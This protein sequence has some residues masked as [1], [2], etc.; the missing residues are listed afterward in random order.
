MFHATIVAV[1]DGDFRTPFS[2]EAPP[3]ARIVEFQ[4]FIRSGLRVNGFI[5]RSL[6]SGLEI[7]P[8]PQTPT[9]SELKQRKMADLHD[10]AHLP[11][12]LPKNKA[13]EFFTQQDSGGVH[14]LVWL[15]PAEREFLWLNLSNI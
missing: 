7:L 8:L 11:K 6:N 1:D 5:S 15:P 12:D 3:S 9:L 4:D 14:F 13:S 2:I 10:M